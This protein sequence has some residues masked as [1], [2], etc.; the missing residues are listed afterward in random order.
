MIHIAVLMPPYVD[1]LL[2]G[3]KTVE[4]RLTKQARAPF[5][6]I[7]PGDRIYFKESAG[8]FRATAVCD[9]VLCESDLTPQRI[10]ELQRDYNHLVCGE[11]QHWRTKRDARF[12][13]LIW[14]RDVRPCSQGPSIRPLQGLAWLTLEDEPAWRRMDGDHQH[15]ATFSIDITPGNLRNNTLYATHVVDRFPERALGGSTRAEAAEQMTFL[16]HD[17]PTIQTD[18]VAHRGLI[19]SRKWGAWFRRHGVQP[20]DRVVFT[21]V[22]DM[23]YFVG[24]ARASDPAGCRQHVS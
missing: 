3:R 17:G 22:D 13:T 4:M 18:I 2:S 8:P 23:T 11:S 14:L 5:E 16:L 24:L 19:R 10:D 20:G 12:A 9:H 15:D 1:L 7:E 6:A 21:P